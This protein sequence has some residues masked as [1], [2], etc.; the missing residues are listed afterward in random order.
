[1]LLA[2]KLAE[3]TD[4]AVLGGT[5]LT[6]KPSVAMSEMAVSFPATGAWGVRDPAGVSGRMVVCAG[7]RVHAALITVPSR[8]QSDACEC[9]ADAAFDG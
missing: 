2:A 8:I 9:E 5:S 4:S 3:V 1:M 6:D 7:L